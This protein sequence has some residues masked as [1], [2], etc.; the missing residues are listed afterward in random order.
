MVI[1]TLGSA[2]PAGLTAA[3]A[4]IDRSGAVELTVSFD[5]LAWALNDSPDRIP[6][7]AV[8]AL[9]AGSNANLDG[10]LQA[11]HRRFQ[12]QLG[13]VVDGVIR[14]EVTVTTPSLA[15]VRTAVG[16]DGALASPLMLPAQATFQVPSSARTV[17]FQFPEVIGD[18]VLTLERP[19]VE[20]VTEAVSAGQTSTAFAIALAPEKSV[21]GRATSTVGQF[22]RLGFLHILPGG[23]D[24]VLFVVGL[25]L[26]GVRLSALLWQVTAFTLAHT[27][28]F[29]L[30]MYGVIQPAPS[31]VEPLIAA[32]IVL[33][34]VDNLRSP[35]L[36]WGRIGVVFLFGLVHGMG[37]AGAL[38]EIS[39]GR[40][41][42]GWA[43][44]G[45]N[46][47]VEL[48]QL[49]VIA[50]AFAAVGWWRHRA[51]YRRLVI[52][53][54]SV[55]IAAVALVWTVQRIAG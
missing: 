1:A 3:Q 19:G 36:R 38:R 14:P 29:G 49:A 48:G 33:V 21:S 25:F 10:R 37:F 4:R 23:L 41:D 40:A 46:V 43:L 18:V 9:L 32:S 54:G 20:P 7:S 39:L 30:A 44:F 28:T 53:P 22:L 34:A 26:L 24:H 12:R 15:I 11:A 16:R 47:G 45:F 31:L 27:V 5:V 42:Y 2:H 51:S 13:V 50:L 55:A 35:E 17:A 6:S 52:V 8:T